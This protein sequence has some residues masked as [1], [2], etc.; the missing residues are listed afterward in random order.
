MEPVS[1]WRTV[2][3]RR[4]HERAFEPASAD[5]AAYVLV[6]GLGV[7]GRYFLPLARRLSADATRVLVPDLPGNG[8]S[9]KP[10]RPL[11][12]PG[13]AAALAAWADAAGVERACFVGNSL[14]GQTAVELAVTRPELVERLVLVGPTFDPSALSL[15]RQFG[16]LVATGV[17]EPPSLV[18]LVVAEYAAAGPLRTIRTA[19]HGLADRVEDKLGRVVAPTLVV[20]GERDR[21][22]TQA[23]AERLAAGLPDARL[24]VVARKAHAVHY[25]A[26]DEVAA[27]VRPATS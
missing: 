16:R 2:A 13:L 4:V 14:G 27:L 26:P 20:R 23:W 9:E 18:A 7:S 19:R 11:D 1:R 3:G 10:P 24:A 6:H 22:C 21:V 12:V 15:V 8:K 25:S 5:A 17:R